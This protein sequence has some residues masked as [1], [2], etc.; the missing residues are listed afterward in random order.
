MNDE[1]WVFSIQSNIDLKV[2]LKFDRT[3]TILK[4]LLKSI[5][6]YFMLE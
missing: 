1:I 6:K 3:K 2:K 4:K 5:S